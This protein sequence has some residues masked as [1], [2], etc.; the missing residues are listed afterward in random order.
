MNRKTKTRARRKTVPKVYQLKITLS[1]ISPPIWRRVAVPPDATLGELHDVIQGVMGWYDE[2]LHEF[3]DGKG[4]RFGPRDPDFEFDDEDLVEEEE[5][6]IG[7]VLRRAQQKIRYVYDFGDCWKHEV[8]L[9]KAIPREAG[10]E[11]PVCLEG[12][13]ACPPE[14]CGGVWGY[15]HL[16]HVLADPEHEEFAELSEWVPEDF[17]PD[18][19]DVE[20]ANSCLAGA[21]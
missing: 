11:Y 16:L 21:R 3:T 2:H 17:D 7:N 20:E 18:V 9:E 19:F 12:K 6:L 14:D 15:Q 8:Q 13:R 10:V 4:R 5:V 1:G